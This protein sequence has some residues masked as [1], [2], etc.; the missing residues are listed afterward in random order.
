MKKF[1]TVLLSAALAVCCFSGL[2]SCKKTDKLVLGF[3][4]EFPPYGYEENGEYVGFDIEYAKKVCG[5]LGYELELKPIDWDSKDAMLEQGAIDFI[6]NGFTYEGRET[7]YEWT[8][9]YLDNSIVVLVLSGS[10]I[11]TLDDLSG[12]KVAVQSDSSGEAALE[13][14]EELTAT[15][16]GGKYSVEPD[17]V[18]AYEKLNAG[19]YDAIA[20]DVGVAKYLKSTDA[21][22]VI[23]DEEVASETYGV[24]F[25]KGNKELCSK[26]SAEM[27]KVG[28]DE[29]FIKGLCEKYGV[30]YNAFLLK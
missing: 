11:E 30:D 26:I 5:N 13:E 29:A 7:E 27:E 6:W 25:K 1:I 8:V 17:Y 9:R 2:I 22:L 24:G 4:A 16:D 10:G 12:K 14:N 28:K 23:L 20:V 19:G 3:D 18:A 21:S 15:F